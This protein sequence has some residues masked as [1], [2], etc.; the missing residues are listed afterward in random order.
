MSGGI[1]SRVKACLQQGLKLSEA[2]SASITDQTTA[3]Q[4]SQW[5]SMAH[6][7]VV[8]A[9]E[10]EFDVMFEADDI[11]ALASVPAIEAALQ[12]MRAK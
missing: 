10:R 1:F 6:L 7:E 5:T 9:L 8:F 4:F 2:E 3:A 12:R 11:A